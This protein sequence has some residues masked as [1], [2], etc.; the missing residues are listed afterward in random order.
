MGCTD[1]MDR[2][3]ELEVFLAVIEGGSLAAAGRELQRSPPAITRVLAALEERVGTRLIERTTRRLRATAAGESLIERGRELLSEY[4]LLMSDAAADP[5]RGLVRITAPLVFGSRHVTPVVVRFL[6]EHP[7][8]RIE[9]VLDDREQNLMG[10]GFDLAV[11]IGHL[12]DSTLLASRVGYIRRVLVA[13]QRYLSLRPPLR[14][15]SDLAVHEV[16]ASPFRLLEWRFRRGVKAYTVRIEPRF[17]LN[18]A[19]AIIEAVRNDYGIAR[20]L[21]YQ[22][23]NDLKAQRLVR[24]LP[25]FEPAAVP[26]QVVALGGRRRSSRISSLR[27]ALIQELKNLDVLRDFQ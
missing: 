10:A 2:L 20:V 22:V 14:H 4:G 13:S 8:V 5:L 9:L 25:E 21:S 16:V 12:N 19:E 11:R 18:T 3:E 15:P 24:V 17:Q 23:A 27:Q 26:V 7:S 1:G 6:K